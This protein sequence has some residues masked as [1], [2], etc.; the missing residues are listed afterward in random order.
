MIVDE[1]PANRA[2]PNVEQGPEIGGF[3]PIISWVQAGNLSSICHD[4]T[5][6]GLSED[7][8][9]YAPVKEAMAHAALRP[10]CE[11]KACSIHTGS[12]SYRDGDVITVDPSR[13]AI[14]GCRILARVDDDD[15]ATF[16]QLV[17]EDGQQRLKALN[18]DWKPRYTPI[19]S[20]M[21]IVG[22]VTGTWRPE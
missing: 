3:V 15:E 7:S 5:F 18:P 8:T 9:E 14:H 20:G 12:N 10:E 22:V 21:V 1:K 16:K 17:I 11:A 13:E 6:S 4:G 2:P 19:K